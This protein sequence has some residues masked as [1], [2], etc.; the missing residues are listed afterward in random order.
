MAWVAIL[1]NGL[2]GR[3]V[4]VQPHELRVEILSNAILDVGASVTR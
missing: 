3:A 4:F 2:Q 1:C